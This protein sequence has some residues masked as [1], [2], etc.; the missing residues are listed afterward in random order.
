MHL[1]KGWQGMRCCV[2]ADFIPSIVPPNKH[3]TEHSEIHINT[4]H[5]M[6]LQFWYLAQLGEDRKKLL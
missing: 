6:A 4:E 3:T 5:N 2:T 1:K